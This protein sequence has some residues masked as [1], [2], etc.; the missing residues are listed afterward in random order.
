MVKLTVDEIG[1]NLMLENLK[2][3][4][5][6]H[7]FLVDNENN[8]F[9]YSV[10]IRENGIKKL[11]SYLKEV[12]EKNIRY[13]VVSDVPVD[14]FGRTFD[15]DLIDSIY[16]VKEILDDETIFC[17]NGRLIKINKE[18]LQN[19]DR[20]EYE[21]FYKQYSNLEKV[22]SE[23][24]C[25]LV[26]LKRLDD[27]KL[28]VVKSGYSI[29]YPHKILITNILY[30]ILSLQRFYGS[31][32]YFDETVNGNSWSWSYFCTAHGE[33]KDLYVKS[34]FEQELFKIVVSFKYV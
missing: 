18:A 26:N 1:N 10:Y 25:D 14:Y 11:Y 8:I 31:K 34:L 12:D 6:S 7:I 16:L 22:P 3:E 4:N 9:M 32:K 21:E 33:R 17:L 28:Y 5:L 24:P 30:V 23:K 20:V 13:I 27:N 29:L 15:K 2:D 19:F